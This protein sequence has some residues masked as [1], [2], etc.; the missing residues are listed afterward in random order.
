MVRKKTLTHASLPSQ[1]VHAPG[2]SAPTKCSKASCRSV[3]VAECGIR[4]SWLVSWAKATVEQELGPEATTAE[5]CA[6]VVIPSTRA[7]KCRYVDI[8]EPD[9]VGPPQYMV[10]HTWCVTLTIKHVGQ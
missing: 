5:V 4:M 8:I 10:S 3:P 6:K 9:N 2:A 7:H 1:V